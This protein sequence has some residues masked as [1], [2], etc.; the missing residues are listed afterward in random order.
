MCERATAKRGQLKQLKVLASTHT[1]LYSVFGQVGLDRKHLTGVHIGIV[2]LLERL[3]QLVELITG[4]DGA[5]VTAL[6]LL[7]LAAEAV[8]AVDGE[9]LAG[10]DAVSC[11]VNEGLL[12]RTNHSLIN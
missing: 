11:N 1:Y 3:L 9:F 4:E 2:G 12:G 6:L 8:H 5:T 10:I 7:L